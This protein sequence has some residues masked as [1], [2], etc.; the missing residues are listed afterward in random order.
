MNQSDTI[1]DG[2]G[3]GRPDRQIDDLPGGA[4]SQQR[5]HQRRMQQVAAAFGLHSAQ[6]GHSQQGQIADDVE[7]LVAH[8]LVG[9]TQS[10]FVQHAVLGQHDGVVQRAAANQIRA[11]Q[12][13]DF[14]DESKSARR[15]DVA[16]RTSRYP[17]SAERC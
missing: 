5:R 6:Q 9:K 16:A 8:E 1:S 17:G 3:L 2:S 7:N 13:F 4:V 15:G 10:G 12:S 14:F 11:S